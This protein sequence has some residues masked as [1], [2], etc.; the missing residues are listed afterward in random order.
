MKYSILFE[1]FRGG[2]WS[3]FYLFGICRREGWELCWW[4]RSFV[5][6]AFVFIERDVS[7]ID[8]INKFYEGF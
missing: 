5:I 7:R 8:R 4:F 2:F 6:F 1:S 3:S